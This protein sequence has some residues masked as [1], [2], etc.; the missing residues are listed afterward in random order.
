[1]LA[2]PWRLVCSANIFHG[3]TFFLRLPLR[4]ARSTG[5]P[6]SSFISLTQRSDVIWFQEHSICSHREAL[7]PVRRDPVPKNVG[8]D[9]PYFPCAWVMPSSRL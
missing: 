6:N 1:M 4:I 2:G 5:A 9:T 7:R 8:A 3:M